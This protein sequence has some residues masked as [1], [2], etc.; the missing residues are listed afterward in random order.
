MALA[1]AP[2]Q[3]LILGMSLFV[4]TLV[5]RFLLQRTRGDGRA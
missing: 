3:M 4:A 5:V 1:V 2:G